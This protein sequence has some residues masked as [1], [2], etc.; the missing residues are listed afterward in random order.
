M[1][2]PSTA[3]RGRYLDRTLGLEL[4]LTVIGGAPIATRA[5]AIKLFEIGRGDVRVVFVVEV[6]LSTYQRVQDEQRFG[7]S[8]AT[9]A[10]D[11]FAGFVSTAALE[12][13]LTLV[14]SL[15]PALRPVVDDLDA[16][17]TRLVAALEGREPTLP[18]TQAASFHWLR[19]MQSQPAPAGLHK[20]AGLVSNLG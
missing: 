6:S 17:L 3:V 14:P 13:E 19:V 20:K 4:S 10:P 1:S 12:L 9:T 8:P 16:G 5:S 2:P 7:F 11:Q 18:L 15:G